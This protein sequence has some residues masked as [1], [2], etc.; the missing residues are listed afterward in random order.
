MR[1]IFIHTEKCSNQ[2]NFCQAKYYK[3]YRQVK[4]YILKGCIVFLALYR[5]LEHSYGMEYLPNG[6][7]KN[8]LIVS[9]FSVAY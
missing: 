4:H 8:F 5:T 3:C 9:I 2:T 1:S 6:D 7:L